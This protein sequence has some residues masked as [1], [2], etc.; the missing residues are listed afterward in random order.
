VHIGLFTSILLQP[1]KPHAN[2][3]SPA[4]DEPYNKVENGS[5][6]MIIRIPDSFFHQ[7]KT[8]E[9]AVPVHQYRVGRRGFVG[10]ALAAATLPLGRAWAD[11]SNVELPEQLSAIGLDGK[12]I[13]IARADIKLFRA[14]L[15]GQ[16]LLAGNEGYE[17]ARKIWNGVFDRHPA[18]IAR[19][20]DSG[21][22]VKAVNFARAH[23]VLTAVRGGGHSI[24]GQSSC[25]GG[26]MIDLAPMKEIRIDAAQKTA[27]AQAGVLLGDLDRETQALGLVTTLGTAS[28]TGIAGL[29][30]GGGFGRLQRKFGLACD[31]LIAADIVT[32]DG[33]KLHVSERENADLFWGIRGGGG[34]FGIVTSFEYQ[35]H[36]FG[37]DLLAG[38]RAFPIARAREVIPV[39][40][41]L[42]TSADDDVSYTFG[43]TKSP[44][45]GLP[46]GSY[47]E[48]EM[49]Y[50]GD[51][52]Q[53]DR[54]LASLDKLGKPAFDDIAVKPYVKAQ[55]GV[56]GAAPRSLPPGLRIYSKS[57]FVYGS[58]DKLMD[59]M[60]A[61]FAASPKYIGDLGFSPMGGAVGRVKPEATAFWNRN[62]N[63]M[64]ML[65]G[66]WMDP[67]LD[68]VAVEGGRH[69]WQAL[70]PYTK[71]H[72]VNAEPGAEGQRLRD[73]YGDSYPRLVKLKNKVD[74]TNLFRLN[75]NIKPTV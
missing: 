32:A 67:S 21:D 37:P 1:R 71:G 26:L 52:K 16:L 50:T 27:K 29:T 5:S 34:N 18:L 15:H 10:S 12:S 59:E 68:S 53:S 24:S 36:K 55:M 23:G 6:A 25:E 30:L 41:E 20:A 73:T 65:H 38:N 62:S 9:A 39:L 70:E 58:A 40:L 51:L 8:T 19:C 63:Y 17:Q 13:A 44:P 22:V 60:L 56:S 11:V 75:S 7:A 64:V 3:S 2:A 42:M 35:L 72:Y 28:D 54:V 46:E 45:P 33:K 66:A 49:I 48:M 47:V 4:A 43:L 69:I 74:P 31:N 57:G 14:S 61:Q